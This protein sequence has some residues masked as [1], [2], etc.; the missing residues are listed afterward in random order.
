VSHTMT[1]GR[2]RA[3]SRHNPLTEITG[4]IARV[5]ETGVKASAVLAASGGMVA[6]FALPA[7]AAPAKSA[8]ATTA[9]ASV[10]TNPAVAAAAPAVTAPA[11]SAPTAD[12]VVGVVGVEAVEKP[13]PAPQPTQSQSASR[14]AS[15]TSPT[16]DAAASVPV[17]VSGGVLSIA[18]AY[19]GIPYRYG[20]T[21]PAGFDCS[22]FTQFVFAQAGI[23]LPRTAT[24]QLLAVTRVSNPQPGDLVFFGSGD[25]A[26]HVGI[27]AGN[28][29]MYDSPRT[30]L[31]SGLRAIWTSAVM[32]GR[33]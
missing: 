1:T 32:Y 30:G 3:T 33:P 24:D 25:F 21:T 10:T 7:Q 14:S 13:A 11:V 15:R 27:Y 28:G 20:G 6:A 18:A 4:I 26:Y 5:G 8:K 12:A 22:G 16:S 2:H 9:T 31:S 29:M 23:S 19:S 17:N